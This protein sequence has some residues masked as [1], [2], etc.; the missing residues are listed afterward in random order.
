MFAIAVFSP[1]LR[2]GSGGGA[3]SGLKR[4]KQREIQARARS[5]S[6]PDLIE[7]ASRRLAQALEALDAAAERRQEADRGEEALA[8][9]LH[10]LGADRAR[11]AAELDA[12]SAR[13]RTLT[14]ANREVAQRI[15]AAIDTI[16]GVLASDA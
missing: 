2:P 1:H 16:R 8:G 4:G 5:M 10:V 11:L 6:E 14:D 15:D 13:S 3:K 12:A 9:Q 7:T